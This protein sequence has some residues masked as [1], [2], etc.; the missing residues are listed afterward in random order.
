[1]HGLIL[2]LS[3]LD[4]EAASAAR[5][6]GFFDKLVTQGADLDTVVRDAAKLAE[7]PVGVSSPGL[8]MSLRAD[9][10]T[11]PTPCRVIPSSAD[12]H[13]LDCGTVVWIARAGGPGPLDAM[14]LERFAITV[15]SRL[16]H[17]RL[18]FPPI[19]DPA[20]VE[21]VLSKADMTDRSRAL[22]LLG[23]DPNAKLRVLAAHDGKPTESRAVRLGS[24]WAILCTGS[25]PRSRGGRLGVGPPVPAIEAAVSWKAARD[26]LRLATAREPVVHW[27]KLGCVA[28]LADRL[29]R[30]ALAQVPDLTALDRLAAER[31][32]DMITILDAICS[33]PS[34]RQAAVKLNCHPKTLDSRITHA[35]SLLGFPFTTPEGK[36]RLSLALTLRRLRDNPDEQPGPA[37]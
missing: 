19:G 25:V 17:G 27:E 14:V 5:V 10:D 12:R 23:I 24:V 6:I 3:Q 4:A 16:D 15:A 33:T 36:F 2:R 29:D 8:G 32:G 21:L 26:A 11:D 22:R 37:R 28:V 20:L 18:P 7:C 13:E 31:C 34:I 9:P 30:P 1:M 35:E